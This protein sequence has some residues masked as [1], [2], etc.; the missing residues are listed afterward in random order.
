M[1]AGDD[2]ITAAWLT[3]LLREGG[4]L[5]YGT[6]VDVAAQRVGVPSVRLTNPAARHGHLTAAALP[7]ALSEDVQSGRVGTG[8]TVCLAACGA[9]FAWG[10]AVVTL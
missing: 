4:S 5:P 7:V 6:V 9:G 1:I 8:A 2:E 3:V 10:A